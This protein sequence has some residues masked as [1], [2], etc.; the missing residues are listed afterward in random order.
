M[1]EIAFHVAWYLKI[2]HWRAVMKVTN[3]WLATSA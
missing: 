1:A 2:L 3:L